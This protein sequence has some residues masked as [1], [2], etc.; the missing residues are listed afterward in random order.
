MRLSCRCSSGL[1][2]GS[3]SPPMRPPN[4]GASRACRSKSPARLWV[5]LRSSLGSVPFVGYADE[6]VDRAV[7]GVYRSGAGRRRLRRAAVGADDAHSG[8][9]YGLISARDLEQVQ[10]ID[11]LDRPP[12]ARY[13]RIKVTVVD[14]TL[15]VCQ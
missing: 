12:L 13:E 8:G 4:R 2:S 5:G 11:L 7:G 10:F 6:A 14:L 3:Q 9:R 1:S 15:L